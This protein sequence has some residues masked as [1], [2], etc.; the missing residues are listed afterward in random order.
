MLT[1]EVALQ[2]NLKNCFGKMFGI[3]YSFCFINASRKIFTLV[4][5][6]QMSAD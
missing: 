6:R 5:R 1:E 4:P 3:K 2:K